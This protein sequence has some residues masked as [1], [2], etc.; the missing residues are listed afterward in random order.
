MLEHIT[1]N[2]TRRRKIYL[3]K[4]IGAFPAA[5]YPGHPKL[6]IKS[7]FPAVNAL[8]SVIRVRL[9]LKRKMEKRM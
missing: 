8:T 2:T 6:S 1:S 3:K 4:H 7:V 9:G 5:K